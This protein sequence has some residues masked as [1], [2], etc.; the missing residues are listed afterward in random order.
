MHTRHVE[1]LLPDYVTGKLDEPLRIGVASHLDECAACRA[2][3]ETLHRAFQAIA[4]SDLQSPSNAYFSGILPRVRERLEER[5]SLSVFVRPFVMRF[6]LPLAVGALMLVLLMHIPVR[7][8]NGETAHN[9]LRPVLSGVDSEELVEI[10]LDQMHRQAFSAQL[11]ENET[12]SFLA[13]PILSSK[14]FLAD[15]DSS[16]V[17][18]DPVLGNDIPG[19]LETLTDAD[20]DM[21]V[22]RLSERTSL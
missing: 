6:A 21:L 12:S 16:F 18:E 15:V 19:D 2:E 4:G 7:T 13:V 17:L 22:A 1:Y 8:N 20:L 11:G 14:Y 5:E 3:L 10:G 9:P